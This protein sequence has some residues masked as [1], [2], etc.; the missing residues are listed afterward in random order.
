MPSVKGFVNE[1][2]LIQSSWRII[3]AAS[4][5]TFSSTS[6]AGHRRGDRMRLGTGAGRG[7]IQTKVME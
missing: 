7:T 3:F 5:F 4:F 2:R 6:Q 1:V